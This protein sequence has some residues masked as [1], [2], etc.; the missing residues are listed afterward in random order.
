MMIMSMSMSLCVSFSFASPDMSNQRILRNSTT[1]TGNPSSAGSY[2]SHGPVTFK[3]HSSMRIDFVLAVDS[4]CVVLSI[5]HP[6][7]SASYL[8][9]M[10]VHLQ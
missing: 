1:A 5:P 7:A 3:V 6:V 2:P 10:S 4:K 8:H 9:G